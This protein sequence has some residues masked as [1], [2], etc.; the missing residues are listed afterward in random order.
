MSFTSWQ[1]ASCLIPAVSA[2]GVR[3]VGTQEA[4]VPCAGSSPAAPGTWVWGQWL[5]SLAGASTK[6]RRS[7]G[8]YL[9]C[10]IASREV[11]V[12]HFINQL[13]GTCTATLFLVG[14][15][16]GLDMI[17]HA[18]LSSLEAVDWPRERVEGAGLRGWT[19]QESSWPEC[20]STPGCGGYYMLCSCIQAGSNRLVLFP[21]PGLGTRLVT[22]W[23][24]RAQEVWQ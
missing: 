11:L 22:D 8:G 6:G 21:A 12:L 16:L 9:T 17:L 4:A 3:M 23:V 24:S 2:H 15:E 14:E 7:G 20:W 10:R 19:G 13:A 5:S 1:E 18:N